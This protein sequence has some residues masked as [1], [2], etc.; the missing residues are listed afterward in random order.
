MH[1]QPSQMFLERANVNLSTTEDKESVSVFG[2]REFWMT[3]NAETADALLICQNFAS[4]NLTAGNDS[5]KNIRERKH[6][7]FTFFF[8]LLFPLVFLNIFSYHT[9]SLEPKNVLINE[10]L[11]KVE[12]ICIQISRNDLIQI[13]GSTFPHERLQFSIRYFSIVWWFSQKLHF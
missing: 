5:S 6:K 12:S 7:D 13:I 2:E 9:H 1:L 3:S 10:L 4:R 8:F 11:L